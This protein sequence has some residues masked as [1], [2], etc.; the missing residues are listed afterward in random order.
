MRPMSKPIL[1]VRLETVDGRSTACSAVI[2]T[3]A[4]YSI[5]RQSALP[6]GTP[7][8]TYRETQVQRTAGVVGSLTVIGSTELFIGLAGKRIRDS[9]LVSTDLL[10]A[11]IIGAGTMQKWDI[12]VLNHNG[13]TEVRVGRDVSDPEIT[14]VD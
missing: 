14:E 9:V 11:L 12:S 4:F 8:L 13:S 3:G 6:P 5:V 2:D 10:Q 7:T 1:D